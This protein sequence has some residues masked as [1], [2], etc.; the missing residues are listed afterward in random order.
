MA[1]KARIYSWDSKRVCKCEVYVH[2]QGWI[3]AQKKLLLPMPDIE[4]LY[5]QKNER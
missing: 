2:A 4:A 5:E 3:S 1:L